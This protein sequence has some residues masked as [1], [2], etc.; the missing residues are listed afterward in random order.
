MKVLVI[1]HLTG[2]DI[3]PHLAAEGEAVAELRKEGLIRDVFLKATVSTLDEAYERLATAWLENSIGFVNHDPMACE[4]LS[5]LGLDDQIVPWAAR[6]ARSLRSEFEP[7]PGAARLTETNGRAALGDFTRLNDWMSYFQSAISDSGWKETVATWVPRLMPAM[8]SMLFHGLIRTAHATRA[9]AAA[10]SE[11]RRGELARALGYWA[12]RY[13]HGRRIA[14][15]VVQPATPDDQPS[16][17]AVRKDIG[18]AAADGARHYVSHP[19]A[20]TLHSVTGAM[21]VHLLTGHI[22]IAAASSAVRQLRETHRAL[23]GDA[24]PAVTR[25]P[26]YVQRHALALLAAETGDEHAVKL[27]EAAF[28]GL[29]ATGDPVFA[30]AAELATEGGRR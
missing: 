3:R 8:G 5:A 20:F 26:R 9:I 27:T 17:S 19:N 4:A 21:A 14:L 7:S 24:I 22:P 1:G 18:R 11:P 25:E 30:V 10:D 2:K 28:R 16:L 13:G 12:A 23:L 29:D 6:N 15:P